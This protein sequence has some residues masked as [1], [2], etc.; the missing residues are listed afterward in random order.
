MAAM[1][2][3]HGGDLFGP[4]RV[5]GDTQPAAALPAHEAGGSA[6]EAVPQLFRSARAGGRLLATPVGSLAEDGTIKI[7]LTQQP[8]QS[9]L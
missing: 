5:A 2:V 9:K 6:Q 8:V 4:G 3:K 1:R 7:Y